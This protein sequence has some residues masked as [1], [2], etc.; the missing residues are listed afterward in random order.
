MHAMACDTYVL[1]VRCIN[2]LLFSHVNC[3]K[4]TCFHVLRDALGSLAQCRKAFTACLRVNPS[5]CVNLQLWA[6]CP[7]HKS[8]VLTA[9]MENMRR[10]QMMKPQDAAAAVS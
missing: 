2:R 7:D 6:C 5:L 8:A 10:P 3:C 9:I 4:G 1:F